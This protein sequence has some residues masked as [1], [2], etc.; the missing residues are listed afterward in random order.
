M[1]SQEFTN[2][3]DFGPDWS[4]RGAFIQNDEYYVIWGVEGLFSFRI[5]DGSK[6]EYIDWP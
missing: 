1:T 4:I 6:V 2:L 3:T 5:D